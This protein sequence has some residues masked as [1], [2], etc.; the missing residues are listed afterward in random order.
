MRIWKTFAVM[1]MLAGTAAVPSVVN[2][3]GAA[4]AAAAP[5]RIGVVDMKYIFDKH[6]T[7]KAKIE[8]VDAQIQAEETS[9]N[10]RRELILKDLEKLREIREDSVDYKKQEEKIAAA[11]AEL[12]LE[13]VRKEKEFA[14]AKAKVLMDTYTEVQNA[15]KQIAEY[16]QISVV[17]RYSKDDMDVKRP[18]SVTQGIGRD[19]VYYSPSIDMTAGV[20]QLLGASTA[21]AA[22]TT[23]S[24]A[25][26][27]RR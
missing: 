9:I 20:L 12:K 13:F 10:S 24:G 26:P 23:A 4:T 22:P 19:L 17:L 15:V 8:A 7:L 25:Q 21:P 11:E 27:T 2:A 16:N 14:E 1:V 18:A 3:Q 5:A 6:P